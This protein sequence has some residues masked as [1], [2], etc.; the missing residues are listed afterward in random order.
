MEALLELLLGLFVLLIVLGVML[1][2]FI[3]VVLL[4]I[5]LVAPQMLPFGKERRNR[6]SGRRRTNGTRRNQTSQT[7]G[8]P[9]AQ[10]TEKKEPVR[11]KKPDTEVILSELKKHSEGI[12]DEELKTQCLKMHEHLKAIHD[13]EA[14]T[15][16]LSGQMENMYTSY[17]PSFI[18]V[19]SRYERLQYA[20][21][22]E[23]LSQYRSKVLHTADVIDDALTNILETAQMKNLDA[24]GKDMQELE[25]VLKADGVA[26]QLELPKQ[27]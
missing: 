9:E 19:L 5:Y 1:A 26:G 25:T 18:N 3:A 13:M 2:P 6:T 21:G 10:K 11:K 15:K 8:K 4:V 23:T 12:H 7:A 17:L 27:Q 14:E 22:Q 24:L 20:D 16:E